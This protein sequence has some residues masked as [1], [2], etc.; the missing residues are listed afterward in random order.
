MVSKLLPFFRAEAA[1]SPGESVTI[2]ITATNIAAG[3]AGAFRSTLNATFT[4]GGQTYTAIGIF[5]HNP[6]WDIAFNQTSEA[7]NFVA[8]G[9]VIDTGIAGQPT[10]SSGDLRYIASIRTG[11]RDGYPGKYQAGESYTI[12]ISTAS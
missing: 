8:A 1:P 4:I 11:R 9:L 10:I 3:A 12:T 6:G 7:T 5:T 2:D